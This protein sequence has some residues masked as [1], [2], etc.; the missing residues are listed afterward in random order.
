MPP[1]S[2]HVCTWVTPAPTAQPTPKPLS[3]VPASV[4]GIRGTGSGGNARVRDGSYACLPYYS[5]T[6]VDGAWAG[7]CVS[8]QFDSR[9]PAGHKITVAYKYQSGG[10]GS[11]C[12]GYCGTSS[13]AP[14]F[15]GDSLDSAKYAGN[16]DYSRSAST[17]QFT[18]PASGTNVFVCRGSGGSARDRPAID[19]ISRC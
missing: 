19:A 8:A 18:M 6:R 10:C 12:C 14:V 5:F 9:I 11:C 2:A 1:Q 15:I 16:L 7:G 13:A 17:Q 3:C 4:S